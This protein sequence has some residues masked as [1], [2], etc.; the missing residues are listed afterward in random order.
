LLAAARGLP[1][2][3]AEHT[4][5]R[6]SPGTEFLKV[7]P[8]NSIAKVPG[9]KADRVLVYGLAGCAFGARIRAFDKVL[10]ELAYPVFLIQWLAGFAIALVFFP[11]TSRGWVLTLA[12]T[13]LI[14]A[15]A[16]GLAFLLRSRLREAK[17][18]PPPARVANLIPAAE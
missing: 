15:G 13:P 16:G 3:T 9:P 10:G 1:K 5:A 7:F 6:H 17:P 12:T 2:R 18:A 11:G 8:P 4:R 14:L